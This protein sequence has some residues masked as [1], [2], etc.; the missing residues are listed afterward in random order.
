MSGIIVRQGHLG[1]SGI[2]GRL[3]ASAPLG[4]PLQYGWCVPTS[5]AVERLV[6]VTDHAREVLDPDRMNAPK[7]RLFCDTPHAVD[8]ELSPLKSRMCLQLLGGRLPGRV[9]ATPSSAP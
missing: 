4:S 8:D 1:H 3:R 5:L 2:L 6:Q 7:A 9:A